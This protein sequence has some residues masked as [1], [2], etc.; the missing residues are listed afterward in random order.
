MLRRGSAKSEGQI[1]RLL[2]AIASPF[3]YAF[4]ETG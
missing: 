4:Y 2:S 1:L 3:R